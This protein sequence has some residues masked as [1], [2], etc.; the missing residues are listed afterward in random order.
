LSTQPPNEADTVGLE[1]TLFP[2]T[3][4]TTEDLREQSSFPP[5]GAGA[6]A[7]KVEKPTEAA[8]PAVAPAPPSLEASRALAARTLAELRRRGA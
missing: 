5:G 4:G 1:S 3:E 2:S 7:G 8:A 6:P